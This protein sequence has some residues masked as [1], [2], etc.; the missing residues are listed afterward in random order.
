MTP[1]P[2]VS[3]QVPNICFLACYQKP[4]LGLLTTP[5][6]SSEFPEHV[7]TLLAPQ[8]CHV[9]AQRDIAWHIGESE[10]RGCVREVFVANVKTGPSIVRG[11]LSNDP[12]PPH[13]GWDVDF[14]CLCCALLS[15]NN[16][17]NGQT[18]ALTLIIFLCNLPGFSIQKVLATFV[19]TGFGT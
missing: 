14:V 4:S 18:L 19:H 3:C 8:D 13:S 2:Y 1:K 16:V 10:K 12:L 15:T 7:D 6:L 11:W 9:I 5:K 17:V